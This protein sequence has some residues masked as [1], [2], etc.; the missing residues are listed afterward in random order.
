MLEGKQEDWPSQRVH[1]AMDGPG[2]TTQCKSNRA[3][4][5]THCEAPRV[6]TP[7]QGLL[8][9]PKISARNAQL[10]AW[11]GWPHLSVS[12]KH[13]KGSLT[14]PLFPVLKEDG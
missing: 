1:R 8:S 6:L 5:S 10:V 3:E 11:P 14:E 9:E 2:G 13:I 7:I 12:G 4:G